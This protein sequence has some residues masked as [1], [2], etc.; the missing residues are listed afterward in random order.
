VRA[1]AAAAGRR[2]A[3]AQAAS[4]PSV[5]RL[6][7]AEHGLV[8]RD[9]AELAGVSPKT[10]ESWFATPG[11]ASYRAMPARHLMLVRATLPAFLKA[12]KAA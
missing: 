11:S 5:L 9:L 3:Q 12:R 1:A 10:V 2:R 4:L 8:Q 7:M 6:L